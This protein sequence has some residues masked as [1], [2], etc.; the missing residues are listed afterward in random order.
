VADMRAAT[1]S[2]A[3]EIITEGVFAS[4]E[5]VAAAPTRLCRKVRQQLEGVASDFAQLQGRLA[6]AHP[7]RRLNEF[8]QRL[9]DLQ[10]GLVRCAKQAAKDR[11]LAWHNLATRLLRVRPAQLL[12]QRREFWITIRHRLEE[13]ARVRVRDWQNRLG[14]TAARLRLLGPEQVLAR[15][16]SVTQD[17]T[18]GKILR[19]AQE[20]KAGQALRTRLQ[21]GEI[22]SRAEK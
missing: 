13:L 11:Q 6:R 22:I 15:G 20:V 14:S 7:R 8:L 18:T 16:Y 19:R 9:D 5:F 21:E 10:S 12:K 4:R 1:P 2:A 3:A 17:A